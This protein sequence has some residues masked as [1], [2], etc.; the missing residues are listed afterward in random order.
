MKKIE[1]KIHQ[2]Y[3]S[4][5]AVETLNYFLIFD[6]YQDEPDASLPRSLENGVITEKELTTD[7]QI[8]VFVSHGHSDHYHPLIFKWEAI[9]P[10]IQYI[11][12]Y[13]ITVDGKE[14]YYSMAPYETLQLNGVEIKSYGSTDRG[15]SYFVRVDDLSIFHAGD[16]NWWHWKSFTRE[17]QL[18]EELDYK[19]EIDKIKE[20]IDIAFSPVD[21]RL[22]EYFYLGGLYL[23]QTLHPK[24]LIPMHF[25]DQYT[26]TQSFAEKLK[27]YPINPAIIQHR[28]QIISFSKY[29]NPD[30]P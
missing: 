2:L 26:I 15:V 19:G 23:A 21:P 27:D 17:Q 6:Y 7:K 18:K 24:L 8:F 13:D 20:E 30:Q 5:Y 14:N 9:N 29:V 11:L 22:E 10:K 25:S 16:L 28:G 3:H 1:A 4:S 12:G